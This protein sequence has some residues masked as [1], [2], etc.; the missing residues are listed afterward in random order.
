MLFQ[1]REA[2]VEIFALLLGA[3]ENR[4]FGRDGREQEFIFD[5]LAGQP[6]SDLQAPIRQQIALAEVRFDR[7]PL[8]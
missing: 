5:N 3:S 2:I 7:I 4:P 6:V 8:R 1:S